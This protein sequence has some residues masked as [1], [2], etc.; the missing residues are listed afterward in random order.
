MSASPERGRRCASS[1]CAREKTD[2]S[3]GTTDARTTDAHTTDAHTTDAHTTDAHTTDHRMKGG[4]MTTFVSKYA[5]LKVP[6]QKNLVEVGTGVR[7]GAQDAKAARAAQKGRLGSR[8]AWR[9]P[10]AL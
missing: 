4:R 6:R 9:V 2:T 8:P 10:S 7:N 1:L 5:I 3:Q